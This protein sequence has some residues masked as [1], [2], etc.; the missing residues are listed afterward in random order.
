MCLHC[1][2]DDTSRRNGSVGKPDEQVP[3]MAIPYG[4]GVRWNRDIPHILVPSGIA[5]NKVTHNSVAI[6][7]TVVASPW[8]RLVGN[9]H[10][11]PLLHCDPGRSHLCRMGLPPNIQRASLAPPS[12]SRKRARNLGVAGRKAPRASS[13]RYQLS[14]ITFKPQSFVNRQSTFRGFAG[15]G[16]VDRLAELTSFNTHQ[17]YER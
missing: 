15:L 13:R 3:R 16:N 4:I 12:V 9:D 7:C 8:A 1:R 11:Y 14:G 10:P 17:G 2:R 6:K 5:R